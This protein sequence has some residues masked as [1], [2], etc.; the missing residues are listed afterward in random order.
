[1]SSETEFYSFELT[2]F[3]FVRRVARDV[4]DTDNSDERMKRSAVDG[5]VASS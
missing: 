2:L 1:M 3:A 4:N 5:R